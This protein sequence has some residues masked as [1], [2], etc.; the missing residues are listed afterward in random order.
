VKLRL[1]APLVSLAVLGGALFVGGGTAGASFT[2][3]PVSSDTL[4]NVNA[5]HQT[6]VDQDTFSW[7]STIVSAFQ[8]GRFATAGSGS[9]VTGF[10]TSTNGGATWTSGTLPGVTI[11]ATPPG[12]HARAVDQSVGYDSVHHQWLIAS[13][14]MDLVGASYHEKELVVHRSTD[15]V[16]WSTP[17]SVVSTLGPD[18]SWIVCDNQPASAHL[19]RCY[20]AYSRNADNYAFA[21]VHT[22]D[23]GVTWSAPVKTPSSAAG[24][25]VQPTVLPNGTL[26][27][28]ATVNNE[29]QSVAFRSTDGGITLSDPVN[30]AP[31]SFHTVAGGLRVKD[32][33]SVDIDA[34]GRIYAAWH[35]CSARALC[36]AND[37]VWSSSLD[38]ITWTAPARVPLD[39]TTSTIDRFTAG[40]AVEPGTSG[41]TAHLAL[42]HYYLANAA[43]TSSTCKLYAGFTESLN[44]GATWSAP[45]RLNS[46]AMKATWLPKTTLGRMFTDYNSVSFSNG[47]AVA[48][49]AMATKPPAV[50]QFAQSM[51]GAVFS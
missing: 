29:T 21:V 51:W 16:T 12:T 49:L 50:G 13:L 20:I 3:Q 37:L 10:S 47:H 28:M 40:L 35:D 31:I 17:V 34:G 39:V 45:V 23:G 5:Q 25:N 22:D 24:Y 44:G 4:T 11:Y 46:T 41:A 32:K 7:G 30:V 2:F 43:C 19:G 15:G 6:Q 9:S 26:V 18:K 42:V 8:V 48:V 36:A 33:P 27:V 38:G 1:A 14:G